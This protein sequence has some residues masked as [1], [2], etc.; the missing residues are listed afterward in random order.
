MSKL[1]GEQATKSVAE[2]YANEVQQLNEAAFEHLTVKAAAASKHAD[3]AKHKNVDVSYDAHD[4]AMDAHDLAHWA[5]REK[6][7]DLVNNASGKRLADPEFQKTIAHHLSRAG[8][9]FGERERHLDHLK[10]Y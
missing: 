4:K 6:A 3:S 2:A 8:H 10:K 5:H 7:I 9:H 1:T